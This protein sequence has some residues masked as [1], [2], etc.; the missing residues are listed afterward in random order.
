MFIQDHV[1]LL[2]N[3]I[4]DRQTNTKCANEKMNGLKYKNRDVQKYMYPNVLS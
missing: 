3:N 2:I 4:K 1:L